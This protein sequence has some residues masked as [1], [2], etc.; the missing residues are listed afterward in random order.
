MNS[1]SKTFFDHTQNLSKR[2]KYLQLHTTVKIW[3][4]ILMKCL[5]LLRHK[6]WN[7]FICYSAIQQLPND[8]L[9]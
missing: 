4:M 9:I 6:S 7:L 5:K 3:L 2:N 1:L 8:K